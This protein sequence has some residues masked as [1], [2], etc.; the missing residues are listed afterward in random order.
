M[1]YSVVRAEEV[2]INK[3]DFKNESVTSYLYTFLY[4]GGSY[5]MPK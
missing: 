4:I 1:Q 3:S 2:L 5:S